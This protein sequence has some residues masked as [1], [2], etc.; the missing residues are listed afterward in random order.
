[1]YTEPGTGT[2]YY[3]EACADP[4]KDPRFT[5]EIEDSR[6][7]EGEKLA[8]SQYS[9]NGRTWQCAGEYWDNESND[10]V[11]LEAVVRKSSWCS[12]KPA[13]EGSVEFHFS[14]ER[15]GSFQVQPGRP[16]YSLNERFTPRYN[17]PFTLP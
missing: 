5:E 9:Y 10:L 11:T 2:Q 17:V 16:D 15:F 6:N 7:P 12:T 8:H 13:E 3:T 14:S 4:S 1:M